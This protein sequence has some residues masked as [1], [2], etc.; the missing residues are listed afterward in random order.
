MAPDTGY[1]PWTPRKKGVTPVSVRFLA[2]DEIA[3]RKGHQYMTV[4]VD[5]ESGMVLEAVQGRDAQCLKPVFSRLR[6]AGAQLEA[7]AVDMSPSFRKA[8]N[9]Y[10]PNVPIV[11][12][13][14]HIVQSANKALD[15]V[16]RTEQSRLE[17][18]GR[19][20]TKGNRY[21]LLK[22]WEKVENEDN[23]VKKL[24][25][26]F[27]INENLYRA[28]LLKE[29]LRQ[30]WK[31]PDKEEATLFLQLWLEEAATLDLSPIRRLAKTIA[32]HRDCI[33]AWYDFHIT[34]GPL[35]G[36]NNK[37]KVLKRRA[38]GYRNQ[39]F[40]RLLILFI[41]QTKFNLVGL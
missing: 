9:D 18:E 40:F 21:L 39:E 16:R 19:K 2:I 24:E 23:D 35:E 29:D 37:I 7:I 11:H 12:D 36:L 4:I 25:E 41:H 27:A 30:F 20:V 3:V 15:E 14:F 1:C 8:I 6:K 22:S 32:K 17:N 26:M 13:P 10:A 33:L 5:L 28:Y 38:Y 34:T 31:Q